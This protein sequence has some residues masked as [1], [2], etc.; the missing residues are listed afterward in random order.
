MSR[1]KADRRILI[2]RAMWSENKDPVVVT[3]ED[4]RRE[5]DKMLAR[6]RRNGRHMKIDPHS[7]TEKVAALKDE[8]RRRKMGYEKPRDLDLEYGSAEW[9]QDGFQMQAKLVDDYE[10]RGLDDDEALGE[11]SD[12]A[13]DKPGEYIKI[14]PTGSEK[15]TLERAGIGPSAYTYGD[16]EQYWSNGS[17][18]TVAETRASMS[19]LGMSK[20]VAE[21]WARANARMFY[22]RA[23]RTLDGDITYVGVVVTASRAGVELG[24]NSLWGIESDSG[25]YFN[26]VASDCAGE[27]ISQANYYID[28]MILAAHGQP[29]RDEVEYIT[30]AGKGD[31]TFVKVY[32]S[33]KREEFVSEVPEYQNH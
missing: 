5:R 14:D 28:N 6:N 27:A 12:Y 29:P 9:E 31:G 23:L 8:L 18:G 26:E 30:G 16:Y 32:R 10:G 21:E 2:Q 24:E 4:A 1:S 7:G 25:D 20:Q 33:G 13:P 22:E 17:T 3:V 11:F 19:K 15:F